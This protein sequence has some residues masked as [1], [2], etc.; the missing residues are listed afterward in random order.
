MIPAILL[1]VSLAAPPEGNAYWPIKQAL[2]DLSAYGQAHPGDIAV[3]RGVESLRAAEELV[4]SYY[5]IAQVGAAGIEH[6]CNAKGKEEVRHITSSA[7]HSMDG[8]MDA[9]DSELTREVSGMD[10]RVAQDAMLRGREG[11]RRA[12]ATSRYV[13]PP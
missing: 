13:A 8:W 7:L 2:S 4:W 10:S 5:V 3:E 1:A 12:I 6:S 9:I 11:L